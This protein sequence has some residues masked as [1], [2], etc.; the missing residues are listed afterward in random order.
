MKLAAATLTVILLVLAGCE[1]S[2]P[3]ST[4]AER[5]GVFDPLSDTLEEAEAVEEL[6]LKK[7]QEMDDALKRLEGAPPPEG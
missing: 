4:N 3:A 1:S 2:D 6:A 7:K 5:D